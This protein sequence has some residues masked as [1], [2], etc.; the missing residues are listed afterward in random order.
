MSF[1]WLAPLLPRCRPQV[2]R[3]INEHMAV[4]LIFLS[5]LHPCRYDR[6]QTQGGSMF[7]VYC[8]NLM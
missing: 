2:L 7:R 5:A 8:R 4:F 1:F 3:P 6:V